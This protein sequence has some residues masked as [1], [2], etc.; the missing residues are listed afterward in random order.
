MPFVL[1]VCPNFTSNAVRFIDTLSSLND[2][3]LGLVAQESV[4]LLPPEIQ[5]RLAAFRQVPDVFDTDMLTSAADVLQRENG[6]IHRLLAAVEGLQVPLA[7]TRARLGVEGMDSETAQ[8]FRDKQRMKDLF[9][10]AGLP[11]A[12]SQEVHTLKEAIRFSEAVGFPLVV[13]PP[14]GAGSLSTF[15]VGSPDELAT[16]L[17]QIPESSALLEEFVTGAEHS[18]DTYSLDGKP[19]F[20][21][22]SHYYPNPLEAMRE[23]WIQWQVLLPR[24]VL[25]PVYDDIR[26]AAFKAL[27]CLG[28]RTGISHMEWFRRPDGSLAISEVAARPPGAQFTT[29]MSRAF[30]FDAIGA[31]ARLM[32][33]NEFTPQQ[34]K[35]AVGAAYLRGQGK[36]RVQAVHGL[37]TVQR[38]VGHLIT[39][40]KIPAIGQEAAGNY[41]GEGFIILRH[42]ETEVVR[43][44]L[45]RVVDVVR[46]RLG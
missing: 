3:R 2:V 26:E 32:I 44:A 46:V 29:L 23:S 7:Q 15:Q 8:N 30:N 24:E 17:A 38:E 4:M 27:D 13:K 14:A 45:S 19:V 21:S 25:A 11:C 20:H 10:K 33:F 9:R 12:R 31:W 40:F 34:Q 42:P 41:E 36:G 18:F 28:M 6:P 43:Q 16:A 5:M 22:I 37:E 1:Y 35:Y 39:D